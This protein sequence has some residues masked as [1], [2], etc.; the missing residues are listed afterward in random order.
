MSMIKTGGYATFKS[1]T[2]ASFGQYLEDHPNNRRV[3][4]SEKGNILSW[5][6]DFSRHPSSQKEFNRR[7]YV[8]KTFSWDGNTHNLIAVARS[9]K[10]KDRIVV[11][12]DMILPIVELVHMENDHAGWDATW[13]ILS[14]TYYGI[15]RSDMIYILKRCEKCSRNPTRRPKRAAARIARSAQTPEVNDRSGTETLSLRL[16][17]EEMENISAEFLD[18]LEDY[19][20]EQGLPATLINDMGLNAPGDEIEDTCRMIV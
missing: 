10:E 11:T 6:K 7:N 13:K 9:S 8:Q 19:Y 18:P 4:S 15:L 2:Q 3:T 1:L 5:L 20:S 17:A 12:E 16:E 14:N